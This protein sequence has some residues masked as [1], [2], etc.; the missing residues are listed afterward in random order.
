MSLSPTT[1]R[2]ILRCLLVLLVLG[3]AGGW[4]TYYKFFRQEP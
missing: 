4:F 2:R 3:L 1:K